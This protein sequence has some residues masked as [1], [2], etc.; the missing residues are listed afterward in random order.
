MGTR[1]KQPFCA[2]QFWF[3]I[4]QGREVE[5]EVEVEA[6]VE[7]EVTQVEVEVEVLVVRAEDC[8]CFPEMNL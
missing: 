3:Q 1:E 6:E 7:V 4:T 2:K 8:P 5:E